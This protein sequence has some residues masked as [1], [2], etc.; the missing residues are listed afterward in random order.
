MA[1]LEP[2]RRPYAVNEEASGG[3]RGTNEV[4]PEGPLPVR[5]VAPPASTRSTVGGAARTKTLRVKPGVTSA[6]PRSTRRATG[7]RENFVNHLGVV[8]DG[9]QAQ[10]PAA[11]Q[12]GEDVDTEGAPHEIGPGPVTKL[13]RRRRVVTRV[14]RQARGD[15][16]LSARGAVGHYERAPVS[17]RREHAMVEHEIDPGPRRYSGQLLEEFQRFEHEMA[18][19]VRPGGLQRE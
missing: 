8:D 18:R 13:H 3:W 17:M 2:R 1:P 9:D 14:G 11:S 12:T 4:R 16:N 19:A 6:D 10:A 15:R 7:A 5:T